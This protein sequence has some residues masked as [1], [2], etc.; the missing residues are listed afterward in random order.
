MLVSEDL[1]EL[2]K[3]SDRIIVLYEGQIVREFK[4]DEADIES[5]G[6]AM[7]GSIE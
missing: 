6:L 3:L 1:D 7:A 2:F 5:V 4:I